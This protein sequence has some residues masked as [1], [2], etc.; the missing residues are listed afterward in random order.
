MLADGS[1]TLTI[2]YLQIINKDESI[3]GIGTGTQM[4]TNQRGITKV[5]GRENNVD[6]FSTVIAPKWW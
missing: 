5:T 1:T 4:A 6:I 3:T 2:R